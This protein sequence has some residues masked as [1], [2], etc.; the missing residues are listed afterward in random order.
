MLNLSNFFK[1]LR[2]CARTPNET[3]LRVQ[4]ASS[5]WEKFFSPRQE[6]LPVYG[7]RNERSPGI[8][9]FFTFTVMCNLHWRS[10]FFS[11]SS[12]SSSFFLHEEMCVSSTSED[13][14][15][16]MKSKGNVSWRCRK[17]WIFM[18]IMIF[19]KICL[20]FIFVKMK[21]KILSYHNIYYNRFWVR[22]SVLVCKGIVECATLMR[23]LS[24]AYVACFPPLSSAL[25]SG[26]YCGLLAKHPDDADLHKL[27]RKTNI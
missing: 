10:S 8:L 12:T 18:K 6:A 13:E 14:E 26:N 1:Q 3:N 27:E 20:I 17:F 23:S 25:I 5:T 16:K 24:S 7:I 21:V 19:V 22:V 2:K 4:D 15:M 11:S 9:H